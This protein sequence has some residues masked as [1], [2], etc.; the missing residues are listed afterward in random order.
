MEEEDESCWSLDQV[1]ESYSYA[2][3][4]FVKKAQGEKIQ[5]ILEGKEVGNRLIKEVEG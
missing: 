3:E 2:I 5:T 4:A 1:G